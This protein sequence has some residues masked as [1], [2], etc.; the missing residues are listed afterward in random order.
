MEVFHGN[1]FAVH[2]SGMQSIIACVKY[3]RKNFC[4]FLQKRK[5]RESLAQRIFPRLRY[6]FITLFVIYIG[7]FLI[8]QHSEDEKTMK[9]HKPKSLKLFLKTVFASRNVLSP[10]VSHS[11]LQSY[12]ISGVIYY[13]WCSIKKFVAI[14]NVPKSDSCF[15]CVYEDWILPQMQ[16]KS[17]LFISLYYQA[18]Y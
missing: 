5:N 9:V 1:T 3:S 17:I 12:F 15:E 8:I 13:L 16:I 4:G 11:S 6:C 18:T 7:Y 14:N 2:W 10:R